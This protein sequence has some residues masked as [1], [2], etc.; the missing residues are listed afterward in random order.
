MTPLEKVREA[1]KY[2]RDVFSED[3]VEDCSC[4]INPPCAAHES[5]SERYQE[6]KEALTELEKIEVLIGALRA[7]CEAAQGIR[8][9]N[10]MKLDNELEIWNNARAA[11]LKLENDYETP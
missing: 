2:A 10:Y 4:H 11:R 9:M 6:M 1:L 8:G 7:E 5:G 3:D